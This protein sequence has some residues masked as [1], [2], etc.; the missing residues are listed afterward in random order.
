MK[1]LDLYCCQGGASAGYVLAGFE[2]EG[3]DII[4]QPHYPYSFHRD[5]VISFLGNRAQ[6]IK[7]NFV[8]IHASP[9]CQ[10]YSKTQRIQGNAH[11][12]LIA[13]TRQ[14]LVALGLPYII[15]NVKD[16]REE[17][18]DPII[19]CG[20]MFS[21]RTYRDRLFETGGGLRLEQPHHPAHIQPTTKMG[22]RPREGEMIH[23]VGNFSGVDLVR[24]DWS[25]EW[26][27]RDGLREAIP[28]VYTQWIGAR[29]RQFLDTAEPP[30]GK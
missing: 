5:D 20:G 22:R 2:V 23:A 4:P 26:A 19:L 24:K 27:T 16:A 18:I 17:L 9:P 10:R 1:I 14:L 28:P 6:W 7:E 12:D 3:V 11:P 21:L 8:A 30:A 13:P 29:L 25:M 15:E